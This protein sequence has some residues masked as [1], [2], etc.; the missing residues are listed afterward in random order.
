VDDSVFKAAFTAA[1]GKISGKCFENKAKD[2][3][4]WYSV[5]LVR[6]Y[7]DDKGVPR[8]AQSFGVN[9]LPQVASVALQCHEW[10]RL[11]IRTDS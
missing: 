8:K 4:V 5:T 9:D 3:K 1:V 2:G 10:I 11:K 7:V 6:H